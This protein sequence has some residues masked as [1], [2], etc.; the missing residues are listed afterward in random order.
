MTK[1]SLPFDDVSLFIMFENP[2]M[3]ILRLQ[4]KYSSQ[5]F[6]PSG[7]FSSFSLKIDDS[8]TKE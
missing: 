3:G 2:V 5:F 7:Q 8:A 4:T 6:E 1:N